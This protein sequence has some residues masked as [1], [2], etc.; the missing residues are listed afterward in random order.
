MPVFLDWYEIY[1]LF[2]NLIRVEQ[3]LKDH[4]DQKSLAMS[5]RMT[6]S[7]RLSVN[8][9]CY[10]RDNLIILI[11]GQWLA[12]VPTILL[13]LVLGLSLLMDGKD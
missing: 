10:S 3:C 8:F 5:F 2:V 13:G 1:K 11:P 9:Q 6:F 7:A 12:G 4:S